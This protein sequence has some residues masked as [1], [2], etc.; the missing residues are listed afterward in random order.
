MRNL[1]EL[2]RN[3]VKTFLWMMEP[4]QCVIRGEKIIVVQNGGFVENR[5]VIVNVKNV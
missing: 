3:V 1:Y 4:Q 5:M 2:M